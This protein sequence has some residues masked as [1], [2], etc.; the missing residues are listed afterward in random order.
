M[1]NIKNYIQENKLNI[2]KARKW[3]KIDTI[4]IDKDILNFSETEKNK[5]PFAVRIM[6]HPRYS[7]INN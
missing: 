6:N 1:E 2:K 5:K 7:D 3:D 4:I